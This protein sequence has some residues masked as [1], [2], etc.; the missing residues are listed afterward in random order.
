MSN[1]K[2]EKSSL[3]IGAPRDADG[4]SVE[5][6]AFQP[7]SFNSGVI[8]SYEKTKE[9]FGSLSVDEVTSDSKFNLHPASRKTLGIENEEQRRL[10]VK[11]IEEVEK[12]MKVLGEQARAEGFA[13]GK[14]DGQKEALEQF[15]IET[16]P[17]FDRFV[18]ILNE[19]ES[20]KNDVFI[21]NEQFLIQLVF[22]VAKQVTL[23]EVKA[24]PNYVKQLCALLVEK[25]GAKDH[26]KIKIGH[27]DYAQVESIRDYLKQQFADLKNIQ[28]DVSDE[29]VN[30]GCKVETDLAR[31]NASVDTQLQL[32]N[33]S[34]GDQ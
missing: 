34:L 21:A 20:A 32:I 9:S 25:I 28:I 26:I 16:K 22:Q 13:Q 23:K 15:K 17:V 31:I 14:I 12:R 3:P 11:I 27:E 30:G 1:F 5:V 18:E 2:Q 7:R 8:H 6:K 29:F 4:S 33:Q 10:E 24:D 19:F